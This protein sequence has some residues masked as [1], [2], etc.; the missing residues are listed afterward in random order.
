MKPALVALTGPLQGRRFVI[1]NGELC[2]GR[3]HENSLQV[4]DLSVSRHHCRIWRDGDRWRLRDLESRDG[5]FVNGRPVHETALAADDLILVSGSTF[6]FSVV[7]S[8]DGRGEEEPSPWRVDLADIDVDAATALSYAA[9]DSSAVLPAGARTARALGVLLELVAATGGRRGSHEIVESVLQQALR[10]IP[11]ERAILLSLGDGLRIETAVRHAAV[12]ASGTA[13]TALR[14]SRTVVEEVQRTGRAVAWTGGQG[15]AGNAESV[16]AAGIRALVA[17]P[18]VVRSRPAAVLY[19]DSRR[20]AAVGEEHLQLATAIAAIAAGAL[21]A[22]LHAERLEGENRRLRDAELGDGMVGESPAL[23][24]VWAVLERAAPTSSTVLLLGES[25]TGK[26]MAARAVHGASPRRE[27]PFVAIN[28]ASLAE[29]LLESELFGHERGAFTGAVRRKLGKLEV[30]HGGTLFLDEVGELPLPLQ[31]KL[32]RLLQ[33]RSFERVGGTRTI[34]VDLRLVA[35]T[36]RDLR[37]AV[38]EGDFRDDL[39]YRLDVIS[40]TLPPLR[41][42]RQDIALLASHFAALHGR[43]VRGHPLGVSAEARSLLLAYDWPGNVREL[44]NVMERAAVLGTDDAVRAEDLPENLLEGRGEV[45][46]AM[47]F[48][49]AV[50]ALKRRLIVEAVGGSGGNVTRAAQRLGL[51]PN[52]LHRLIKSFGLRD[53]IRGSEPTRD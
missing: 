7:P 41:E 30:A 6:L 2:V 37:R 20:D 52:H 47:P 40:V 26:E 39:Y 50:N 49:D 16:A 36:N 17:A 35:A 8:A 28:C 29:N 31:A 45:L 34:E 11:A 13:G 4:P 9:A 43:A 23:R 21:D 24:K 12:G 19:L 3:H 44:S 51:H 14:L 15:G 1:E 48:H 18:L 5:T 33:E 22:A 25:G 38:A 53:E 10:G 27:Q 32:L 42:R 46:E